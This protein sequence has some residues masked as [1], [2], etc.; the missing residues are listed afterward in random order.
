MLYKPEKVTIV[1]LACI[2]LHNFLRRDKVSK[3]MYS[4]S[5][6]FDSEIEGHI[7]DGSWRH[8]VNSTTLRPIENF[9]Y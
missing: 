3:D 9:F 7:I 5:N 8:E 4:P 2:Y 6:S 1:V